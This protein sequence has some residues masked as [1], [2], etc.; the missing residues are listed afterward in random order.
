MPLS[1]FV[2]PGRALA[3]TSDVRFAHR[4]ISG[5]RVR[6]CASPQND[7]VLKP[8]RAHFDLFLGEE[9][10]PGM[11][12]DI[13]SLPALMRRLPARLLH[14]PHLAHAARTRDTENLAGLV[15]RQF[16]DHV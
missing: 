7:E 1:S 11:F 3:R 14:H 8:P 13:L 12:D 9:N 5:F 16:A 10:L 2:I 6:C 4:G 15:A